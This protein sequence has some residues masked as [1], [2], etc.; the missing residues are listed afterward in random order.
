MRKCPNCGE[1]LQSHDRVCRNCG[2][3]LDVVPTDEPM[4]FDNDNLDTKKDKDQDQ[5]QDFI[6]IPSYDEISTQK[7][8]VSSKRK[9]Y[10]KPPLLFLILGIICILTA[11]IIK[12]F[13]NTQELL[14]KVFNMLSMG[15]GALAVVSAIIVIILYAVKKEFH[16]TM[17]PREIIDSNASPREQRRMAF[18]GKNYVKLSKKGFS[19]SAFFFNFYY[20]LY[21]KRYLTALVGMFIITILVFL[22]NYLSIL[23]YIIAIIM[24]VFSIILGLFFNKQYIKFINNKT[25]VLKEKNSNLDVESFLQ[26]CQKKGGTS[27]FSATIIYTLFLI[28]IILISNL[29]IFKVAP[30]KKPEQKEENL[31]VEVKVI[32]RD[33]QKRKAQCKNY[34]SAVYQSYLSANLEVTY[35]GCN[36]GKDNYIILKVKNP[37]D[38]STYIAKYEVN[39]KKE[40]LKLAN[41]T[42][43]IEKLREKQQQTTL[44]N[45]EIEDLTEKETIEREFNSFD[46]QVEEDKVAYKED[47]TYIRNYIKI[48]IDLL[49]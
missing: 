17:T 47:P 39:K 20:L 31:D 34:A 14:L 10:W 21:R 38:Q 45:K 13:E 46:S 6:N 15:F 23:K 32:D 48:D 35:I 26:L 4:M 43:E 36:M 33:Y 1:T 44:T 9:F 40:E 24:I 27:L 3:F 19:F 11:V 28:I 7:E 5:D 29:S 18:V 8:N 42:L 22:S 25:K 41:T 37:N 49:S 16:Y 30:A 12:S 2:A